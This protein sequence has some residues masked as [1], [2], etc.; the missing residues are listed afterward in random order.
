MI[1]ISWENL[2]TEH[3]LNSD[4]AP[5]LLPRK[6]SR[7]PTI[8]CSVF[9]SA[10]SF[11]CLPLS[12]GIPHGW[13]VWAPSPSP[14][15]RP[16]PLPST[17]LCPVSVL[18]RLTNWLSNTCH[19]S[20]NKNFHIRLDSVPNVSNGLLIHFTTAALLGV[21]YRTVIKVLNQ[22]WWGILIPDEESRS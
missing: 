21:S 22:C 10:L 8:I 11:S 13:A 7:P 16:S 15:A 4:K 18:F 19:I 1:L 6:V 3:F 20:L 2:I 5:Y 12:E 9:P 17:P 14:S